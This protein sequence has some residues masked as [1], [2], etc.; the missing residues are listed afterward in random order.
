MHGIETVAMDSKIFGARRCGIRFS[1]AA[2]H[3][4]LDLR[5]LVARET[6]DSG[7]WGVLGKD[8]RRP[9]HC[10][11]RIGVNASAISV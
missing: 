1:G 3:V 4:D 2:R 10:P 5:R 9:G 8:D 11:G 7:E 6:Q